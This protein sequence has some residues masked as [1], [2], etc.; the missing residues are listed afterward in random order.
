MVTET[1]QKPKKLKVEELVALIDEGGERDERLKVDQ[2]ELNRIKAQILGHAEKVGRDEEGALKLEGL[3]ASATVAFTANLDV[4][5]DE[6]I[7][8]IASLDRE[9]G[10]KL[11]PFRVVEEHSEFL[12]DEEA[13]KELRKLDSGLCKRLFEKVK[14]ETTRFTDLTA[15]RKLLLS[16]PKEDKA[17]I[18]AKCLLGELATWTPKSVSFKRTEG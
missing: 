8:E 12:G 7:T 14:K 16:N 9:L 4:V 18:E 13:V 1:K 6:T 11:F 15:V 2:R 10:E 3:S 17:A 5:P